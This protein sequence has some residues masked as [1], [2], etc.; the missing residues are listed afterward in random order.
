M[1]EANLAI[2]RHDLEKTT[3][4]IEALLP[5]DLVPVDRFKA[6][7]LTLARGLEDIPPQEI[8]TAAMRVAAMGLDPDPTAQQVAF[9]PFFGGHGEQRRKQLEIIVMYQGWQ[10]LAYRSGEYSDIQATVVYE[11]ELTMQGE[12][13]FDIVE[14]TER[15]IYHKRDPR[16]DYSKET[17]IGVYA[18]AYRREQPSIGQAWRFLP[19][20]RVVSEHKDKSKNAWKSTSNGKVPN[21]N[22]PWFTNEPAMWRKTGVRDLSKSLRKTPAWSRALVVDGAPPDDIHDEFQ[23]QTVDVTPVAA[24]RALTPAD[25]SD[26]EKLRLNEYLRSEGVKNPKQWT[27]WLSDRPNLK[28]EDLMKNAEN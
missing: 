22:S 24:D 26:E 19:G 14:G 15:G 3:E 18:I 2:L 13:G 11:P 1:S 25:F 4:R 6:S 5:T 9:V 20:W 10:E 28:K 16:V 8:G 7:I 27:K 23:G 12:Y 17:L 21:P